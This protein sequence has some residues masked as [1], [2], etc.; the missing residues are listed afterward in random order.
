M[1]KVKQ[2]VKDI[3]KKKYKSSQTFKDISNKI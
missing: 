1:E 3:K 2:D